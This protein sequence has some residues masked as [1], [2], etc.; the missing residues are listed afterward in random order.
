MLALILI[1]FIGKWFYALAENHNKNKWATA[2]GGVATYY[3]GILVIGDIIVALF[4]TYVLEEDFLDANSLV[5]GLARLPFGFITCA[6]LYY[7]LKNSWSRK[8]DFGYEMLDGD[9]LEEPRD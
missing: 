9:L 2:I 3:A 4:Y 1:Y 6:I 5:Y 7:I 8:T